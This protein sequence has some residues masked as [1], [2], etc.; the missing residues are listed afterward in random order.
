[1][2]R[3]RHTAVRLTRSKNR[4][5]MDLLRPFAL[6]LAL[7]LGI[8]LVGC[9]QGRG[10]VA[11]PVDFG[12]RPASP[13]VPLGGELQLRAVATL[14]G[15]EQ[16]DVSERCTWSSSATTVASVDEATG[17]RGR[18]TGVEL[19]AAQITAR[20]PATNLEHTVALLVTAP[21][22]ASVAVTPTNPQIAFGTTQQFV[23]TGTLT[24]GSTQDVTASVTWSSSAA[25]TA[26]VDTAG[27]ASSHAP[28]TATITATHAATGS[29]GDTV[30]TVTP[31]VLMSLAVTPTNPSLALGTTRQ[32]TATGTFS[33]STVQDLTAAVTW[34]SSATATATVN[35]TG[36]ATSVATGTTTITALHTGSGVSGDTMLTVTPAVLTSIAVTP[37]L[38]SI[39]LGTTR[40]FTATGT[41]SDR[42]TQDLTSSVTW[43]SSTGATATVDGSG[44]ATSAAI[45]TTTI[46]A[47]DAGSGVSGDTVLT[48]TPAVL[49]SI[50]VTPALPS[51]ALGTMQQ[52]TATGTYSDSSTQDL[53]TMVTWT[54]SATG[55]AT[56]SNA[57]S[58]EGLATSVTAG[59]STIT[60]THAGSGVAGDTVLTVTPAVLTSIVVTPAAPSI[61]LGSTR[62]FT[63]TGTYSDA[64]MQDVTTAVTWTSSATGVA[65]ISN[66]A[67]SEGL[68][69]SVAN[70]TT[71]ITATHAGSGVN[72]DTTLSVFTDIEFRAAA[73]AG[74]GSGVTSLVIGRPAGVVSGDVLVA[75]LAVRPQTAVVTPPAGWTLVRRSDNATGAG[76]SLLVFQRVATGSEPVSYTWGFSAST[77][78][79]GGIA[80]FT[81][82]D[83]GTVID[84]EAAQ[85]TA[86][87]V[88]HTAPSVTTT[89]ADTM[90]VT[91]HAFAS[92]ATWTEPAG[93]AEAFDI[94]SETLGATGISLS[95]HYVLRPST[96]ATGTR[97]ATA[98]NDADTGNAAALAL[99]RIP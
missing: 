76:S 47:T 12:I 37:A 28:G 10:G 43:T 1:M 56:V 24:D 59:T 69:T 36:L 73:Q 20:D 48:I 57:A 23:A 58:S 27:L 83:P 99:R 17:S 30:L 46:T 98:S 45:G 18:V 75:G 42:S 32:F 93:M 21:V 86:S 84:V 66:A 13:S 96:G 68:A 62:Q 38:P 78:S 26:T 82:V 80:A 97:A 94:A 91:V 61:V 40:Q 2:G 89:V 3:L 85:T 16:V 22:V 52:F 4:L 71:T 39:A 9:A 81:H 92:S 88:V 29:F 63:A 34:T 41:Y 74:A 19:G 49:A 8:V 64:S 51:I 6:A 55:V 53:T 72:G 7:L 79:A 60:A 15:G 95:A 35:G 67:S 11:R 65:T 25:T 90:L 31:A 87:A 54:S 33:D 14:R 50:A 77:G 44:L 5:P 70:G